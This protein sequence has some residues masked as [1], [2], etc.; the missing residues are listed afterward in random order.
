MIRIGFGQQPCGFFP[1]RFL[2]AKIKTA[3]RLQNRLGGELIF[4]YHDSDHDHRETR[5]ILVDQ[6]TGE[7]VSLN[8]Q[9]QEVTEKRFTPLYC[10]PI[11][12]GWQEDTLR[13]L[14]RFVSTELCERFASVQAD[15]PADFC[16]EMYRQQGLL[17]GVQ[18]VRSSNVE[19]RLR[20]C[21]VDDFFADLPYRGH[22]VRARQS[23][24]GFFL[25]HG[26]ECS[27][28]VGSPPFHKSQVSPTRDTRLVWMQS[29]LGLTHYVAGASEMEYLNQK[30][31]PEITFIPRDS[32]AHPGM[33]Y[34]G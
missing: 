32:I 2:W 15:N 31:T 26:G 18:V 29:V 19:V 23:P 20:A 8:F 6:K 22:I 14:A 5:T 13:R 27:E 16:L 10:K 9:I 30:E 3:R 1:K 17:Q 11:A 12:P 7:P 24:E 34:L 33:A 4:F 25:H 28:P 21:E